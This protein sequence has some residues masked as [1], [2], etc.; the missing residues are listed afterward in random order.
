M[1]TTAALIK[2]RGT[3]VNIEGLTLKGLSL[4]WTWKSVKTF[5]HIFTQ[6][7][8]QLKIP[9]LADR[10]RSFGV[11][12]G[13]WTNNEKAAE[14][15]KGIYDTL[16]DGE[17]IVDILAGLGQVVNADQSIISTTKAIIVKNAEGATNALKT[18]YPI[19]EKV[20]R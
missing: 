5:G 8:A 13:Q 16:K 10:A 14:F 19:V 12:I 9:Q 20:I 1:L 2:G 3:G 15:I 11:A 4:N 17:N 18:G 6:H 7:G